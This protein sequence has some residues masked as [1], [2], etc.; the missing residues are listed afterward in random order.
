MQIVAIDATPKPSWN[1]AKLLGTKPTA[2]DQA[3]VCNTHKAAG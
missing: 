3:S 1:K 2:P